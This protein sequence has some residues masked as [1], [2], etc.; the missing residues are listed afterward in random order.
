MIKHHP[1]WWD[2]AGIETPPP[3]S[4]STDIPDQIETLIVGAG[5]TGLSAALTLARAGRAV[6]VI[7]AERAGFGCSSRNGGLIGPSFHKLGLKGLSKAYGASAANAILRESMDSLHALK[8]FIQDENIECGLHKTGRFRGVFDRK[9]YDQIARQSEALQ[10]AVGLE[11][12]MV[13][14]QDQH[15]EIGSDYYQ[16]GVIYPQDGHLQPARL[17]LG[18]RRLALAAGAKIHAPARLTGYQRDGD[19]WAVTIEN[20][21]HRARQILIATNGYTGPELPFYR[22][23]VLPIRSAILATAPISP[24]LMQEISPKNRGFGDSSRLI[25]YYRPSPD[26]TRLIFGGRAFN[27]TDRPQNYIHDLRRS[28]QHIFP[29]LTHTPITHAWSGTVAY[30]FDHAPHVGD[31]EG[32]YYAMGYCGSG[33]GRARYFGEKV[34]YKMLGDARGKTA[35]DAL[36]FKSRP[37][38]TGN[39]WFMPAVLRWNQFADRFGF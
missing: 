36:E 1:Y 21:P 12:E 5:Y 29:Q 34:A 20:A 27:M 8:T 39:P 16:G 10:K 37:L 26:G 30:S 2:D 33:V 9:D 22:R 19:Q 18:L 35:L 28:M 31:H 15:A 32:V 6:T 4:P 13:S 25:L 7:D 11:F 3:A 14:P 24:S 23:R 17:M 38:Y